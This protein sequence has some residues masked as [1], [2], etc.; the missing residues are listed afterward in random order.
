MNPFVEVY[1]RGDREDEKHNKKY[2]TEHVKENG[3]NP[4]F[5]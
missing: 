4:I 1:I 5:K 3:F 2:Q